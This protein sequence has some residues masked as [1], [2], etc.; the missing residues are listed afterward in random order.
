MIFSIIDRIDQ[1]F[2]YKVLPS[3]QPDEL[4]L[5]KWVKASKKAKN[6]RLKVNVDE[7]G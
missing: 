7:T 2:E 6:N 5:P 4:K 3:E 1:F